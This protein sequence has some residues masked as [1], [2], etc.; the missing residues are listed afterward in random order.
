MIRLVTFLLV[1]VA[2][3]GCAGRKPQPRY[4]PG[5]LLSIIYNVQGQYVGDDDIGWYFLQS[6]TG[7]S[8]FPT[9]YTYVYVVI[10]KRPPHSQF[11][12]ITYRLLELN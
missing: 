6:V 3:S 2:I 5:V 9:T 11:M 8:T 12:F 1:L 10:N 7:S 4:G